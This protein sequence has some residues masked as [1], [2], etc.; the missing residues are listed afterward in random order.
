[1]IVWVL[2][3]LSVEAVSSIKVTSVTLSTLAPIQSGMWTCHSWASSLHTRD[4]PSLRDEIKNTGALM[5]YLA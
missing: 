4:L 5:I 2:E 3:A 1:M